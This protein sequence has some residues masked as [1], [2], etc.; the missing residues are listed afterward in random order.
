MVPGIGFFYSGLLRRKNAL[1]MIYLSMGTIA[2]VSFQVSANTAATLF[3][4]NITRQWF[5]WGFSLA[6]SD[7]A[8]GFI[9]D[10]R[11]YSLNTLPALSIRSFI[12]LMQ[13][14]SG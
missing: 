8:N 1:S 5:F 14:I 4:P 6:F 11:Q 9:G 13:V 12:H 7:T 2:V 3:I 10:L